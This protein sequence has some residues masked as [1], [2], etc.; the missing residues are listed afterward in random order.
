MAARGSRRLRPPLACQ[1]RHE[2]HVATQRLA[3]RSGPAHYKVEAA[4]IGGG[5]DSLTRDAHP[6][7]LEGF[8]SVGEQ[9]GSRACCVV[10]AIGV[11]SGATTVPVCATPVWSERQRQPQPPPQAISM[12][13][14]GRAEPAL[15]GTALSHAAACGPDCERSMAWA[16][17]GKVGNSS[18]SRKWVEQ[19]REP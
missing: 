10:V 2:R 16:G 12:R 19:A 8:G 9:S 3:K 17:G 18:V 6:C 4:A 11:D 5:S 14:G 7:M 15:L 1:R 13:S